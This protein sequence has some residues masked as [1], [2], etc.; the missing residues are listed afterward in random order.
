MFSARWVVS[1]AHCTVGRSGGNTIIVMGAI[2]RTTGGTTF[3]VSRIINH[4][5]YSST[6][7]ANDISVLETASNVAVT[8]TIAP[9]TLGSAFVGGGVSVVASG[10]GQTSHPGSAA[11]NLQFLNV[12]TLTNADCRSRFS[13]ANAARVFDNTICTF[14]R[15]GEG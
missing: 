14:T 8:S 15:T 2:S 9:A 6:T 13:A 1:A 7:L 4:P 12:Q 5:S 3:G 11:A 10:W